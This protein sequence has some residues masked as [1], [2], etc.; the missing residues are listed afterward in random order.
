MKPLSKILIILLLTIS[1]QADGRDTLVKK[2]CQHIVYGTG[3]NNEYI[4]FYMMG[5][6]TGVI[7]AVPEKHRVPNVLD[8]GFDGFNEVACKEAFANPKVNEFLAKYLQGVYV[9]TD[10]RRSKF[11]YL[12]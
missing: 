12:K 5:T 2:Q 8:S 4:S 11:S 6:I 10:K 9:T 1:I 3:T 7:F